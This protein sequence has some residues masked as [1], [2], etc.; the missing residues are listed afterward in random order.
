MGKGVIMVYDVDTDRI[1]SQ[2]LYLE[3]CLVVTQRSRQSLEQSD[4]PVLLFAASRALHIG[5]ECMIDVGSTLIDGF[6][7][8]DPGGYLDIVDILEDERVIPTEAVSR[9][10]ELVRVRDRL[11]RRY[12]QVTKEELLQE[13]SDTKVLA[14]FIGWVRDYLA[15]ELESASSSAPGSRNSE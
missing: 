9:L 14:S 15:R 5:M 4:D 8:R 3:Q 6:I 13:L 1:E 2:L 12:D 11:V 10:K 7:M